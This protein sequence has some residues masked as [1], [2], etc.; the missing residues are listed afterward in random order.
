MAPATEL[1]GQGQFSSNI[2]SHNAIPPSNEENDSKRGSSDIQ[3][4]NVISLCKGEDGG[5]GKPLMRGGNKNVIELPNQEQSKSGKPFL[6]WMLETIQTSEMERVGIIIDITSRIII[7]INCRLMV[8]PKSLHHH[9]N[10]IH[11][12]FTATHG[13]CSGLM[14]E[15]DISNVPLQPCSIKAVIFGL[16]IQFV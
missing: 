2:Q 16:L 5:D 1:E 13:F 4:C 7:C 9:L 10:H 6:Q 15:Y 8:K 11:H 3:P 12:P 14:R